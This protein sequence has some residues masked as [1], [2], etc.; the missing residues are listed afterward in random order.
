[1]KAYSTIRNELSEQ[2][3]ASLVT[4]K[5]CK[6]EH[7]DDVK[8]CPSCGAKYSRPITQRPLAILAVALTGFIAYK[9]T[10]GFDEISRKSAETE[11]AKSPEQKQREQAA[12]LE[13]N[14]KMDALAGCE[15]LVEKALK[16]PSSFA[17][18][19]DQYRT[20]LKAGK[21]SVTLIYR[22]KNSFGAVVPGATQCQFEV[23]SGSNTRII[24]RKEIKR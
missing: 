4:C 1:M 2:I 16:D 21:G 24:S 10:S 23:T 17:P 3:M 19:R 7:S 15:V 11:S 8:R 9:C 22:A 14:I 18:E 5:V 20:N 6:K 13:E 12:N